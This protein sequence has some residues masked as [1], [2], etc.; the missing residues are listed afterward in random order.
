VDAL[1][2]GWGAVLRDGRRSG[3]ECEDERARVG[4]EAISDD[5]AEEQEGAMREVGAEEGSHHGG[6]HVGI[7]AG[8]DACEYGG[9]VVDAGRR[10][11]GAE[12]E[13]AGRGEAVSGEAGDGEDGVELEEAGEGGA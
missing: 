6:E 7:G 2:T 3:L 10:G 11:E 4:G 12:G 13:E 5:A 8:G 1:A 9:S